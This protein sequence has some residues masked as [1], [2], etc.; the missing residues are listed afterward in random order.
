MDNF[1]KHSGHKKS[2]S[3]IDG[4]LAGGA[5]LVHRGPIPQRRRGDTGQIRQQPVGNFRRA[6]G[7][8]PN[9]QPALA[10]STY[11]GPAATM[12]AP[13][14]GIDMAM[15]ERKRR[16]RPSSKKKIILRIVL[17]L[18]AVGLLTG[19]Y[20]FGK[21]YLAVHGIFK[22]GGNAPALSQNVDPTKLN[23]E[24]DGRVNV[25]L[26]GRGGPGHDGADLTDTIL[27]ASIDPVNKN[28]SILSIPR[29]LWVKNPNGGQSKIN[30]VFANAKNASLARSGQ[31]LD[32]NKKAEEAGL[33]A[34]ENVVSTSMGIPLH[35]YVLVDFQAFVQAIN[36]VGGVDIYVDP[37]DSGGI[38]RETLWD[39][40]TKKN[41]TLDVKAG[42]NH[43]DGQRA[44]MYARSRHT[45]T[46]GDF[47][48][49]T[50]QRKII[51]AL[52]DKVMSAGTYGN[53][54]RISQLISAFG[55][56]V[57]SNL[58]T[59]EIKRL[60]DIMKTI[61]SSKINSVGLAD[62]PNVLVK[63]GN[64]NGQSIVQPIAG[65]FDFSAIQSFV[66]NS[67]K[68]GYIQNENASIAVYNG[69]TIPGLAA[70]KANELK[71][72]GYNITTVTNAPQQNYKQTILV[73]LTNGQKKYTKHYLEQRLK[74]TAVTTMPDATISA[75]G[76]DFVVILGQSES[77]N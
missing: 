68:D 31:V 67:I 59:D 28:A 33:A 14:T 50:R 12:P 38:V 71:S 45:S 6:D 21:A 77:T 62:P 47:D 18:L 25:L 58:S 43:F 42:Q 32:A 75:A 60:Y 63:T 16:K 27:V 35:Y 34:V 69:S 19:G 29:D 2:S 76:A 64:L 41:Y 46:R 51:I 1:R 4:F 57:Q 17:I 74:V 5:G 73:D 48:R 22:G 26:L 53:P 55:S 37:A 52:K 56:H 65:L 49:S 20:I 7:F 30:A 40:M 3:A 11:N 44:L 70:K 8:A 72:Y 36:T 13:I 15:P 10:A 61:D 9:T 66:R 24:G 54:V 39:E 23:G